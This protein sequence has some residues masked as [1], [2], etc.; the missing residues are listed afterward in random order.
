[1]LEALVD[2][3]SPFTG[4]APRDALRLQIPFDRLVRHSDL[5]PISYA[6][7]SLIPRLAKGAE[8]EFKDEQGGRHVI[9]HEPIFILEPNF[10]ALNGKK[11]AL[12]GFLIS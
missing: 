4:L 8:L 11:E 3:G 9:K 12:F 7:S 1:M 6:G 10:P 2:T 5:P